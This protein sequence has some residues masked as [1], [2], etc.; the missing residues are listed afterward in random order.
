MSQ[1]LGMDDSR[2]EDLR[3]RAESVLGDSKQNSSGRPVFV[4]FSGTPKSG[5]STCIDIVSHFFRRVGF[6]VLAPTEGASKRTPYYLRNDL[7][8]FNTWS[9]SYALTH[10]LEGLH[11][12]DHYHLAILDRGLFDALAW[13][14]LLERNGQISEEVRKIIQDFILVENW[15]AVIDAVFLFNADSSTAMERENEDKLISE[16][17]RAMNPE[18]LDRLNQSYRQ[19]GDLYGAQFRNFNN[20]DTSNIENTTAQSTAAD[21]ADKILDIFLT[22]K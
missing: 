12:S 11:H 2:K 6:N 8:A 22:S 4:E 13:F 20:I 19:V 3:K 21:V 9:A 7:V 16:P 17:G 15:R 5:K 18:F 1:K 14:Q 10:I